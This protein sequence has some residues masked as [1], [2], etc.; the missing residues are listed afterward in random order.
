MKSFPDKLRPE[1]RKQFKE[2]EFNRELCKLR[3]KVYEYIISMDMKGFDLKESQTSNREYSYSSIDKSLV[4]G[5]CAEL[6]ELG[7]K[8]KIA[9][10]NTVLF[11]YNKES[12][13]PKMSDAEEIGDLEDC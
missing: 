6:E 12:E 4:D 7:W 5:I 3:A 2:F 1:N 10:G 11:I 8:T 9:Y 13:L